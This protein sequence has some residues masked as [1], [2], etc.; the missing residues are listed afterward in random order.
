VPVTYEEI[1]PQAGQQLLEEMVVGRG[2]IALVA[3]DPQAADH[4]VERLSTDLHL[5]VAH[6][7]KGLAVQDR[8]PTATDVET[9]CGSATVL[10]D[11]EVLLWPALGVPLLPFLTLRGRRRPTIAVW[12][13][14]IVEQR[15]RYSVRG[16]PDHYDQRLSDVVVLRPRTTRFPDEVPFEM[17]RI[18]P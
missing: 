15:A 18:I 3:G 1:W 2:R 7:G 4:L 13:G 17:E 10:I 9:V 5:E 14:E 8:V 12:P 16:R 6:L 11:L